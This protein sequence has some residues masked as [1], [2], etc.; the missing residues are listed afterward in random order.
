MRGSNPPQ[1]NRRKGR[2]F[3]LSQRYWWLLIEGICALVF[4]ILA[5]FW[6]RLTFFLFLS[7][8]G[9]YA[10]V[11][12]GITF[13]HGYMGR[14]RALRAAQSEQVTAPLGHWVLLIEGAVG[15]IAGLLCL[16][17]PRALNR[18]LLFIIAIWLLAKGLGFLTQA[19]ARGWLM[20][21]AGILAIAAAVYLFIDQRSAF[22][23][24]LLAIGIYV[25]AMGI[26]LLIRGWRAWLAQRPPRVA[27]VS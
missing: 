15:V 11:D 17:L 26:L 22:R 14:K 12:G 18:A 23:N 9:V 27:R 25:L 1:V 6:P 20:G 10:L 21:G 4:G 3:K 24:I 16:I 19:H 13:T 5:I 8:F 7:L 2:G